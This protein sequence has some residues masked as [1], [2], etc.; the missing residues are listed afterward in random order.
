M[1][2]RGVETEIAKGIFVTDYRG[3]S[4]PEVLKCDLRELKNAITHLMRSNTE[5]KKLLDDGEDDQEYVDAV[6]ENEHA[7]SW[8]EE[9]VSAIEE[10]LRE[11]GVNHYTRIGDPIP[12][13]ASAD[14]TVNPSGSTVVEGSA[15]ST[16]LEPDSSASAAMDDNVGNPGVNAGVI[17]ASA[18]ASAGVGADAG[19]VGGSG[20]AGGAG[21]N[22]ISAS[23]GDAI[24]RARSHYGQVEPS[25]G[26][27]L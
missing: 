2:H 6:K 26:I 18:H 13:T 17:D 24:D 23:S 15:G 21:G 22:G 11:L 16:A 19:G 20:G 3:N 14:A 25:G 8:R 4:N 7:I 9:R 5:L 27:A 12:S 1:T 10:R